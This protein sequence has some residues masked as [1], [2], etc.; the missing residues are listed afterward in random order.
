LTG[1][2]LKMAFESKSTRSNPELPNFVRI[3]SLE[4]VTYHIASSLEQDL[5]STDLGVLYISRKL[6][7][8]SL[9]FNHLI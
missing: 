7:I 1:S 9:I 5:L 6:I 2:S 4:T 3:D 8:S